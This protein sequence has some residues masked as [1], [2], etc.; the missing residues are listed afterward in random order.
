VHFDTE[1]AVAS[2]DAPVWVAHGGKDRLIPPVMG[3]RVFAAAKRKGSMLIVPDAAHNDVAV[4]G[5]EAYWRW[6]E[7]AL[8]SPTKKDRL[9][10]K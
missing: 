1:A 6:I 3:N 5:G 2:I 8:E 4:A 10:T 9:D 7:G